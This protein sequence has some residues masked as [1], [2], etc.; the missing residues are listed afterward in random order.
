MLELESQKRAEVRLT[1]NGINAESGNIQGN[2]GLA[3]D[4]NETLNRVAVT[5]AWKINILALLHLHDRHGASI[6]L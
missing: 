4:L 3:S 2:F 1:L 5:I 6:S